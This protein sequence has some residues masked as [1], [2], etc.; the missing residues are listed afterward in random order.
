ME[1]EGELESLLESKLEKMDELESGLKELN[2]QITQM[3]EE[4]QIGIKRQIEETKGEISVSQNTITLTESEITDLDSQ[5][6]KGLIEIDNIK[7]NTAELS[8]KRTEIS[9]VYSELFKSA[10]S[11]SQPQLAQQLQPI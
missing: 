2:E 3:G 8:S 6:R 1:G 5:R 7:G 11:E 4:E 10:T 9:V